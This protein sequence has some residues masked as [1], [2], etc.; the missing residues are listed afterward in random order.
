MGEGRGYSIIKH[1]YYYSYYQR[2]KQ[3]ISNYYYEQKDKRAR[4]EAMYAEYGG[5]IAFYENYYKNW[6]KKKENH[7]SSKEENKIREI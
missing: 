4:N 6:M 1:D 5:E 7:K 2:N 3:K